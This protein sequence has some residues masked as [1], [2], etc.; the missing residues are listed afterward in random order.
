M[1]V[2]FR[3]IAFSYSCIFF[4][5]RKAFV[6]NIGKNDLVLDLGSGDK[7]FWRA[8]VIVDKYLEDD[9]QRSSGPVLL[10]KNKLFIK[11]DVENLPFKDKVFDFVYCSHLLEHVENPVKAINEITRVG[12]SGYIEVPRAFLELLARR[13][14]WLY[15]GHFQ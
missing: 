13:P 12:K 1:N 9:R 5:R 7:P 6:K 8:D 3:I 11:A 10:D 15:Y 2:L 4:L 14:F